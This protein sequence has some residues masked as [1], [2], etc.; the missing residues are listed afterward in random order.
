M[1]DYTYSDIPEK[2]IVPTSKWIESLQNS[3]AKHGVKWINPH[4][5]GDNPDFPQKKN[6]EESSTTVRNSAANSEDSNNEGA[7]K[8]LVNAVKEQCLSIMFGML[9]IPAIEVGSVVMEL[10]KG[11]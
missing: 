2:I 5:V 10:L 3:T 4:Y 1:N 9:R 8:L 7:E 11:P 6:N